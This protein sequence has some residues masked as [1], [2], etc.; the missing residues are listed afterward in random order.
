L[1]LDALNRA[2]FDFFSVHGQDRL[3]AVEVDAEMGAFCRRERRALLREPPLETR[4]PSPI[5]V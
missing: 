4:S 1:L 5:P 2:C 3:L